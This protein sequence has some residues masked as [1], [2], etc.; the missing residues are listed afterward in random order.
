MLSQRYLKLFLFFRILFPFLCSVWVISTT[1]S[2]SLLICSSVYSIVDSF[3]CIFY[4]HYCI[5]QLFGSLYFV[6]LLCSSI[7]LLS[8]LNIFIIITLNSLMVRLLISTLLSLF[9]CFYVRCYIFT[10]FIT[11]GLIDSLSL[12]NVFL[13]LFGSICLKS[14]L[15]DISTATTAFFL[16]PFAWVLF[17]IFSL[18]VCMYT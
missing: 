15:S 12:C 17:S 5:L 7:L 9:R 2:S 4:F 10:T 16:F 13:C 14:I 11:S 3:L 6:K 18:S 1:L 8:S